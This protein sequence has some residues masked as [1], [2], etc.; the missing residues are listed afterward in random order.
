MPEKQKL[1]ISMSDVAK[2]KGHAEINLQINRNLA[3][4][5]MIFSVLAVFVL[6]DTFTGKAFSLL[7]YSG[8]LLLMTLPLDYMIPIL[9]MIVEFVSELLHLSGLMIFWNKHRAIYY[10]VSGSSSVF[11]WI[12]AIGVLFFQNED[13]WF[14]S[15]LVYAILWTVIFHAAALAETREQIQKNTLELHEQRSTLFWILWVM[16]SGGYLSGCVQPMIPY[17]VDWMKGNPSVLTSM[18]KIV[19]AVSFTG[20]LLL[21]MI[22]AWYRQYAKKVRQTLENMQMQHQLEQ[23]QM[24]I[25]L[26]TEKYRSLQQYQHDFKKH[27]SYIHQLAMQQKS[28]EIAEYISLVQADLKQGT[29]LRLTGSQ[30]LDLLLSDYVQRAKNSGV[31]LQIQYQP[32]TNLAQISAPDL[33]I[34]LGNLLDNA[35]R[36]SAESREKRVICE[37][38]MKNEYYA[39]IQLVN[40]CDM[41]P[42]LINGIPESMRNEE[43][44]GYGVQNVLR[45]VEKYKGVYSFSYHENTKQFQAKI[46]LPV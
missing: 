13:F 20:L 29:L 27:L 5:V 40:S 30:T 44:H 38:G 45:C 34:I 23:S 35:I 19:F 42:V 46:M 7:L 22:G 31:H 18:Q 41:S 14:L 3:V 36:A 6:P 10:I 33:C 28:E 4:L 39:F 15:F 24:Y 9:R 17:I 1:M 11:L 16:V 43:G 37:F 12:P 26:L 21:A 2:T 32:Q 25:T 8:I